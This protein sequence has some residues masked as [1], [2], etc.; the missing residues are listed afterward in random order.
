MNNSRVCNVQALHIHMDLEKLMDQNCMLAILALAR[1][2]KSTDAYQYCATIDRIVHATMPLSSSSSPTPCA[3]EICVCIY[4]F[5]QYAG[6]IFFCLTQA[7]NSFPV[8]GCFLR[9][10]LW[11]CSLPYPEDVSQSR[12]MRSRW[13]TD[14]G[15]DVPVQ[16]WTKVTR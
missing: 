1:I 7:I 5:A 3:D 12:W 15:G 9:T 10:K 8:R 13:L 14:R 4:L 2:G 6:C 11:S 16:N